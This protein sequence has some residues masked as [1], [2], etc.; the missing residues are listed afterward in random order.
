MNKNQF[1]HIMARWKH[2]EQKALTQ[3]AP[4]RSNACLKFERYEQYAQG[5][6]TAAEKQHVLACAYCQKM[7]KLFQQQAPAT[8]RKT[9]DRW[10]L[11]LEPW[12]RKKQE[13]R[14]LAAEGTLILWGLPGTLKWALPIVAILIALSVLVLRNEKDTAHLAQI[15]PA[16]YLPLTLR[17]ESPTTAA[18]ELFRAGMVFYS[19]KNY[20]LAIEK[21]S[22]AA[23][24]DSTWAA[25]F[26]YL[27]VS[28]LLN[29][30]PL[31]AI[32]S[33][34]KAIAFGDSLLIEKS[35]WYLG[36]AYLL[37][38]QGSRARQAF[39]KV[40]EMG[41]DYAKPASQMLQRLE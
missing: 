34:Q 35:Y 36:N 1:E 11:W 37:V 7:I 15:E 12:R 8:T 16:T 22:Q 6:H 23:N 21:L 10:R 5:N 40:T 33:L 19:Q 14:D 17:G 18:I 39:E 27:G 3:F 28:Q 30:Q 41:G 29:N 31:L 26:F 24:L 38:D 20:P 4:R 9:W 2:A 13:E 25:G 32:P